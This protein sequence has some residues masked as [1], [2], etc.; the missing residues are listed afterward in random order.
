MILWMTQSEIATVF[1]DGRCLFCIKFKILAQ[2]LDSK[3]IFKYV[4]LWTT[5]FEED[6]QRQRFA[7]EIHLIT[8]VGEVHKGY[9][10]IKYIL[11]H[12]HTLK[13]I[14]IF[15]EL[16]VIDRI[17]IFIYKA[18]SRSRTQLWVCSKCDI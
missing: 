3:N 18:V 1:F 13:P 8:G 11:M 12:L 17:G 7:E 4:N 14:R 9:Y 16:S 10:A 6:D 5:Q 2:K 15:I